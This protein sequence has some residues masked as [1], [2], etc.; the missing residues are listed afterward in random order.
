MLD[1]LSTAVHYPDRTV[2]DPKNRRARRHQFILV[3]VGLIAIALIGFARYTYSLWRVP[4]A[5]MLPTYQAGTLLLCRRVSAPSSIR[6]GDVLVHT[7]SGAG[8]TYDAVWRVVGLPGDSVEIRSDKLYVNDAEV[9]DRALGRA[10]DLSIVRE[11]LDGTEFEVGLP[12]DATAP[13]QDFARTVVPPD[14]FFLLGD[15]RHNAFDSRQVGP[16]PAA[17]VRAVVVTAL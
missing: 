16:T 5:G 6:R 13:R 12:G 17:S 2:S 15:N 11:S 1:R 9:P 7:A 10:G 3:A 4:Q 8:K 14:H